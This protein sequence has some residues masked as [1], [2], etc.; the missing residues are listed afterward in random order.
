MSIR[1]HIL[2]ALKGLADLR[3]FDRFQEMAFHLAKVKWPG[4]RLTRKNHD[5]GADAIDKSEGLVLACGWNG[6]L[7]KLLSDCKTILAERPE[8]KKIVFATS[9]PVQE[10][11]LKDWVEAVKKL[12]LELVDVIHHDWMIGELMDSQRWIASEYLDVPIE[13]FADMRTQLPRLKEAAGRLLS[14]GILTHQGQNPQLDLRISDLSEKDGEGPPAELHVSRLPDTIRS[15]MFIW[16]TGAAG[17]G[18]TLAA[19]EYARLVLDRSDLQKIPLFVSLRQWALQ[20]SPL[21]EFISKLPGFLLQGIPPSTLATAIE[22][23]GVVLV[24]NGWN[25][26]PSSK[27]ERLAGELT[28]IMAHLGGATFIVTC[29]KLPNIR[30]PRCVEHW[31]VCELNDC[32]IRAAARLAAIPTPH[33]L[34]EEILKHPQ[35]SGLARIPLFLWE[36]IRQ[37]GLRQSGPMTRFSL[38]EGMIS[39]ACTEHTEA[40]RVEASD[41]PHV[42]F[43]R[44]LAAVMCDEQS[45]ALRSESARKIIAQVSSELQ[46][47]ALLSRPHNPHQLLLQLTSSHLLVEEAAGGVFR[48]SHHLIQEYFAATEL[49]ELYRLASEDKERPRLKNWTWHE[50]VRLAIECL[51]RKGAFQQA[52]SLT[53]EYSSE[54]F[55]G[56]CRSIG[57]NAPLWNNL[58]EFFTEHIQR[59]AASTDVNAKWLA[60]RYGAATG[61]IDFSDIVFNGL[62]GHPIG[63]G[64]PYEHLPVETVFRALGPNVAS[65]IMEITS[66]DF[67]LLALSNLAG[68]GTESGIALA[69]ELATCDSSVEVRRLAYKLL[70]DHGTRE[71][72]R[73]FIREVKQRGGWDAALLRFASKCPEISIEQYRR[74]QWRF[75]RRQHEWPQR[76]R[77][78]HQ[79]HLDDPDGAAGHLKEQYSWLWN[80]E[81]VSEVTKA[82][83]NNDLRGFRLRCLRELMEIDPVWVSAMA[84]NEARVSDFWRFG[85]LPPRLLTQELRNEIVSDRIQEVLKGD[86]SHLDKIAILA[87][88]APHTFVRWCLRQVLSINPNEDGDWTRYLSL[89]EAMEK[90]HRSIQLEV[91]CEAEFEAPDTE[92]LPRLLCAMTR[93]KPDQVVGQEIPKNVAEHWRSRVYF[94]SN[95]LPALN[96][97]TAENWSHICVLL[98]ELKNPIDVD[99]ILNCLRGDHEQ[100]ET[101]MHSRREE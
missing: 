22:S 57:I 83:Q 30:L 15:G 43:L 14:A 9:K 29:R 81:R 96:R 68:Q 78:F 51:C 1:Q 74:R 62:S 58:R 66:D 2:N 3:E 54:D 12:G 82:D 46:T 48:F 95:A 19:I 86:S 17:S 5:R 55:E 35:I 77:A 72:V 59:L 63:S 89:T 25:E 50:P 42:R 41:V 61:H 65:R 92:H 80:V 97:S 100:L 38:L 40:L 94:W 79:W 45:T 16:L 8:I 47:D 101:H 34:A 11:S 18:K 93:G 37:S 4:L 24:L 7:S 10:D 26:I 44:R 31:Q 20:D 98:A 36:I 64:N 27:S 21:L 90:V 49:A 75:V 99:F 85:S 33:Q 70:F 60:A 71:I 84:A 23:G 76:T 52:A 13:S 87:E 73:S 32:E 39:R 88:L 69:K 91:A 56:A 28:S 6:D 53:R 67:R